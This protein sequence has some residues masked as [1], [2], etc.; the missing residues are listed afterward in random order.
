L[1]SLQA[2]A[3]LCFLCFFWPLVRAEFDE[4]LAAAQFPVLSD[5]ETPFEAQRWKDI[6]QLQVV[7]NPVRHGRKSLRVQLSTNKYSGTILFYFHHDWR[8]YGWLHFSVYNPLDKE[9]ILHARIHD[10]MH[11]QHGQAF[12]DRFHH[13]FS[14]AP[15]WN[16]KHVS[17]EAVK[18]SPAGRDMDMENIEA[19]GIFVI[20]QARPQVIYV[21]NVYLSN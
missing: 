20:N 4:R 11:R 10:Q 9:L 1:K 8:G 15:G 13:Q 5:F 12:K 18:A 6:H 16:D 2:V 19:F 21:D 3:I 7:E 17:L 14:L